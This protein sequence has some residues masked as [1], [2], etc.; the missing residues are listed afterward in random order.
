M[1]RIAKTMREKLHDHWGQNN[2]A[3]WLIILADAAD[4]RGTKPAAES[5]GYGGHIE[6]L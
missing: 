1:T 3:P 4:E 6:S 5:I 2:V